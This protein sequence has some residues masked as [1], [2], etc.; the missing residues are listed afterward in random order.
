MSSRDE[1]DVVLPKA[2]GAR[3]GDVVAAGR[4]ECSAGTGSRAGRAEWS[5]GAGNERHSR[6]EEGGRWRWASRRGA[7]GVG[8]PAARGGGGEPGGAWWGWGNR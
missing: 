3:G 8:H 5:V 4:V 2:D 1:A 6:A 7:V